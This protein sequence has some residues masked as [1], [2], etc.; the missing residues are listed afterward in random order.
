MIPYCP[1]LASGALLKR[2]LEKKKGHEDSETSK[3]VQS[4]AKAVPGAAATTDPD[5]AS[6]MAGGGAGQVVLPVLLAGPRAARPCLRGADGRGRDQRRQARPLGGHPPPPIVLP[7]NW[8][9]FPLEVN[10]TNFL[11]VLPFWM[12]PLRI[13]K[14]Q[15][16]LLK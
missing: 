11:L 6:R 8:Q 10:F 9:T 1:L 2:W 7:P 12:I 4:P 15:K 14:L 13:C 3:S 16:A 5:G